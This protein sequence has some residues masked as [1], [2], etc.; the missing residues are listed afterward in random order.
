[1]S[2]VRE[3]LCSDPSAWS[4]WACRHC[5]AA[6]PAITSA[7][8]LKYLSPASPSIFS[9]PCRSSHCPSP[10]WPC[11][12]ISQPSVVSSRRKRE[13]RPRRLHVNEHPPP[14]VSAEGYPHHI[15]HIPGIPASFLDPD[16]FQNRPDR[17]DPH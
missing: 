8:I 7:A 16:R 13:W 14:S 4:S 17:T 15:G 12:P 5:C 3:D 1:E 9:K 11:L 2:S 6:F 10:S